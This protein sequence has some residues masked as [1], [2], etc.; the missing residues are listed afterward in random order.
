MVV[1]FP[2]MCIISATFVVVLGLSRTAALLSAIFDA[3]M[4]GHDRK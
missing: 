1:A 3:R 4:G 2:L